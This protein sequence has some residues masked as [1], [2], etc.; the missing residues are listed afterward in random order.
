[1][2]SPNQ[3]ALLSLLFSNP[4]QEYHMNEIGRILGKKPGVFQKA[5]NALEREGVLSSRR[6][7]NQRLIF[8]NKE[9]PLLKEVEK[10]I[11]KTVGAEAMLKELVVGEP[12]IK[13]AYIF[14]SYAK[15][16]MQSHSDIDLVLVGKKEGEDK[17][18]EGIEKI[19]SRI[20]REINPKFYTPQEYAKKKKEKDSFLTEILN[21]L[22]VT[23]KGKP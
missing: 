7:G 1:M 11:Q 9:Y 3:Q 19:E 21:D 22:Y 18:L 13:T 12:D 8:L 4:G 10:I 6:R 17:M 20:Q 2:F 5:L 15:D 16:K 14:G 23:L